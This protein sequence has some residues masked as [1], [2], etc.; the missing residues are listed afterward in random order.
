MK[1]GYNHMIRGANYVN[2]FDLGAMA[3]EVAALTDDH[4]FHIIVLPGLGSTQAVLGAKG[5]EPTSTDEFDEFKAGDQRLTK[6]LSNA[7]AGGHEVI[8]FRPVRQFAMRGLDDWNP[9]L[10]RTINGYDAAVIWKG[11][12]ASTALK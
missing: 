1:F 7:N 8:D 11:G 12:H 10:I 3:D 2:A 9:D 4:A 5:F 6:V